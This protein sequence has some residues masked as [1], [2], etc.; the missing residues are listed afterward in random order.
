M[1]NI[2]VG[3]VFNIIALTCAV[4][5]IITGESIA[6]PIILIIVNLPIAF[7]WCYRIYTVKKNGKTNL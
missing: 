3:F 2:I 4:L 1:G 5:A 7:Y 6:L